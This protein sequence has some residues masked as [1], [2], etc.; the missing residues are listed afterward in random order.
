MTWMT[1][2]LV[3]SLA[4]FSVRAST[5]AL[6]WLV[7]FVTLFLFLWALPTHPLLAVGAGLVAIVLA[8]GGLWS[9]LNNVIDRGP[10]A[11]RRRR[12]EAKFFPA[13]EPVDPYAAIEAELEDLKRRH[14]AREARSC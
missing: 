9:S 4:A 7:F 2:L 11:E 5:R 14:A 1:I 12:Y 10:G 6:G 3:I 8:V 13:P